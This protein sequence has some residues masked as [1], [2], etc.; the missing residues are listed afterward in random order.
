MGKKVRSEYMDRQIYIMSSIGI[1]YVI[2]IALFAIPLVGTFV[3]IIIKGVLDFK[4]VILAG[5]VVALSLIIFY[6]GKLSLQLYRKFRQGS[7]G[8]DVSDMVK[9][10]DAFQI[11]LLNGLISVRYGGR[12][13]IKAL[14]YQEAEEIPLLPEPVRK[15]SD[16]IEKLKELSELKTQGIIDEEEFSL[17]KKKLISESPESK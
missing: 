12:N 6:A 17:L 10:G 16:I 8:Q 15:E 5:G 4:A 1:F 7:F 13:E 14:P 3:V 2:M 9:R 11:G